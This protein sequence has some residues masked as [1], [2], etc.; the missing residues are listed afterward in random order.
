MSMEVLVPVAGILAVFAAML[1]VL[2]IMRSKGLSFTARVFTALG[3]GVLLGLGIQ[4][5]L[6]RDGDAATTAL[7]WISIVGQGYIG[8]LKML[9]MPLVFVA[10]VGAFTRAEVTEHF[11]R[12]A[13][14][15]LA[16]L[17]G[18]VT[19]AAVLGWLSLIHI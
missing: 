1:V 15:V 4:L 18:T 10:I 19:V 11:G 2:K 7:D 3:L 14:A 13:F 16:V 12:I 9:V 8:L 6:G 17:L 5:L